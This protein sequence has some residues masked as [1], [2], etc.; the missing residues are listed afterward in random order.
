MFIRFGNP[1]LFL[2]CS[3]DEE[4]DGAG[5]DDCRE[6]TGADPDAEEEESTGLERDGWSDSED[7]LVLDAVADAGRVADSE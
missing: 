6:S 7:A 3:G 2:P 4:D 1:L 5:N